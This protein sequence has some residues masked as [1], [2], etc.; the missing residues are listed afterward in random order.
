[1]TTLFLLYTLACNHLVY[2]VHGRALWC[3][4]HSV[5]SAGVAVP[6]VAC[7]RGGRDQRDSWTL[8]PFAQLQGRP[9]G[10]PL[11]CPIPPTSLSTA[12]TRLRNA[13]LWSAGGGGELRVGC[14]G[15][16]AAAGEVRMRPTAPWR[17]CLL[18]GAELVHLQVRLPSSSQG[19]LGGQQH[20]GREREGH[21]ACMR[22]RAPLAINAHALPIAPPRAVAPL[23]VAHPSLRGERRVVRPQWLRSARQPHGEAWSRLLPHAAAAGWWWPCW[24]S[25]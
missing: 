22:K 24:P 8:G 1:M 7:C 3:T 21:A 4:V 10:Q 13:S 14:G 2:G 16:A 18:E 12:S 6:V 5:H 17:T 9:T 25:W 20:G 19:G 15:G 11:A 23:C